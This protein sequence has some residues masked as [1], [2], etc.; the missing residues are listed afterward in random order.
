MTVRRAGNTL[1][2]RYRSAGGSGREVER[3]V[4][5]PTDR[6]ELLKTCALLAG[7]LVRD[8]AEEL[9]GQLARPKPAPD[10]F[11]H[12]AKVMGVAPTECAVVED[13]TTGV[14]AAVAAGMRVLAYAA[15]VH[16]DRPAVAAL[17]ATVFDDMQ[18]LPALLQAA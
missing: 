18:R 16:T 8:E 12:A 2:L 10:L 11:L 1:V 14:T 17:G 13:T 9:L 6:G 3:T 4:T 7:N 15:G 5:A